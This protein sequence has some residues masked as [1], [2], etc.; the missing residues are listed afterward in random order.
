MRLF[1][2]LECVIMEDITIEKYDQDNFE[3]KY[4]TVLLDNDASFHKYVGDT[5][6]LIANMQ[7]KHHE[8]MKIKFILLL[9][10]LKTSSVS[11]TSY[12]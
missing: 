4:I 12:L 7:E 10:L 2:F 6:Y 9:S 11:I 5:F 3:H 1:Y 8:V